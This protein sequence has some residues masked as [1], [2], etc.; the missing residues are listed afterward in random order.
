MSSFDAVML[1]PPCLDE[2]YELDAPLVMGDKSLGK[3]IGNK[4]GGMISN[5]ACVVASYGLRTALI[6]VLNRSRAS[7]QVMEGLRE[8]KVSDELIGYDDS[9]QDG[10]C[11][12]FLCRGER[13]LVVLNN[14]KTNLVL[15]EKQKNAILDAKL[16]Y[17]T[18][19]DINDYVGALSL[20]RESKKRGAVVVFDIEGATLTKKEADMDLIKEA[21]IIFVNESGISTLSE[22]Y[23][24]SVLLDL[25][26]HG[27]IVVETLGARGCVVLKKGMSMIK[28]PA[29]NV[30]P[31]DTTGAGDTFNSTFAYGFLN[32][33]PLEKCARIANGAAGRAITIMGAQS[34]A[35]GLNTVNEFIEKNSQGG[36][37]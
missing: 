19:R 23:G 2:Y 8:A 26:Q 17:T 12:I 18:V 32:G 21:S 33:W 22:R 11:M 13:S 6:D 25:V 35:C 31:V 3:Y 10:K 28:S 5:A 30:V 7:L 27:V 14:A 20:V 36:L 4:L 9:L 15:T 1:G 29:F 34:G 24:D 16:L 37:V